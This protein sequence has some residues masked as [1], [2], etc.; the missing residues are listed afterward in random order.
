MA[1][2]KRKVNKRAKILEYLDAHP[3]ATGKVVSAELAKEGVKVSPEYV[4]TTKSSARSNGKA[5]RG[6]KAG[7]TSG[8]D[9]KQAGQLMVQAVELV[10]K[11]G[12]KEA[13][14]LIEM[15]GEVVNKFSAR[16]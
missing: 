10:M 2:R 13:Q 9:M 6:R 12:Y 14:S 16:K 5:K 15:A 3:D 11:A 1:K 4:S 7:S 8:G